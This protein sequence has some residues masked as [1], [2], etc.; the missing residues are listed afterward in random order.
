MLILHVSLCAYEIHDIALN[1]M[2]FFLIVRDFL[3][4]ILKLIVILVVI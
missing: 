2:H 1:G 4:C 3:T